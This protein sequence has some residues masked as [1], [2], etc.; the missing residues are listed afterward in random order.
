M[1][2]P[3]STLPDSSKAAVP[4]CNEQPETIDA[5]RIQFKHTATNEVFE[6]PIHLISDAS[7]LLREIIHS[8]DPTTAYL[9]EGCPLHQLKAFTDMLTL[10]L[11]D[12]GRHMLTYSRLLELPITMAS[13]AASDPQVRLRG[14]A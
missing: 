10:P 7:P 13:P 1:Q 12:K 11:G 5:A 6:V 14:S 3:D 8:G 4:D 2:Q 9:P